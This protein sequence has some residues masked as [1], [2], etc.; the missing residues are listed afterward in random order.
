MNKLSEPLIEF[1][2][3]AFFIPDKEKPIIKSILEKIENLTFYEVNI[4]L[5][6]WSNLT[7]K[8]SWYC[9]QAGML[10]ETI[11]KHKEERMNEL[12]LESRAL[13]NPNWVGVAHGTTDKGYSRLM[14]QLVLVKS[15][16]D[17]MIKYYSVCMSQKNI[18]EQLSNNIRSG[19]KLDKDTYYLKEKL[20]G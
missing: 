18:L 13:G 10:V 2:D 17:L 20:H 1:I 16:H 11:T 8:L 15:W 6:E 19:Q 5:I 7:I 14:D 3:C 12:L 4:G 9:S